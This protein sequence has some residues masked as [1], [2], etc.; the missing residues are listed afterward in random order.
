MIAVRMRVTGH[1][2]TAIKETLRQCSPG[3]RGRSVADGRD[4][5]HYAE[6]TAQYACGPAGTRR[7]EQLNQHRATW[8]KLEGRER[9][10][11]DLDRSR[12]VVSR[13]KALR[14]KEHP[15]PVERKG[16]RIRP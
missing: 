2:Q 10:V 13:E 16:P 5:G 4:W 12:G 3:V 6:R 15:K 9:Q 8:E 11:L 1:D 14:E 7:S